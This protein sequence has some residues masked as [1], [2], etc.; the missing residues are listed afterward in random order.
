MLIMLK[1]GWY[2]KGFL[3]LGRATPGEDG[4]FQGGAGGRVEV[5]H[6]VAIGYLGHN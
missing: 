5:K 4:C 1:S 3:C 6:S 2:P